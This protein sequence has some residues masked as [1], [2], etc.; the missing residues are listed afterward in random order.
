MSSSLSESEKAAALA[1]MKKT[2][3]VTAKQEIKDAVKYELLPRII[4][5]QGI[6]HKID[7][8]LKVDRRRIMVEALREAADDLEKTFDMMESGATISS[9]GENNNDPR[10]R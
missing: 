8:A 6:G 1:E 4:T 3:L 7:I 10:P 2:R 5:G 9:K